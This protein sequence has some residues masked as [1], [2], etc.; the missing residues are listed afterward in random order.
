MKNEKAFTLIELLTVVIILGI[1]LALALPSIQSYL[2][3]GTKEYYHP[4]LTVLN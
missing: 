2:T 3:R 1:L 4:S